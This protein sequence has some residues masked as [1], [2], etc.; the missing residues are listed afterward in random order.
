[1]FVEIN[2]YQLK[3]MGKGNGTF[4]KIKRDHILESGQLISVAKD[5]NFMVFIETKEKEKELNINMF[6]ENDDYNPDD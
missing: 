1:M 5:I 4:L 2:K 3:D 6:N